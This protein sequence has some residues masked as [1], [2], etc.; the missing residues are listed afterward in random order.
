M[1]KTFKELTEID[2]LVAELYKNDPTLERSKFGYAYKRFADKNF[3]PINKEYRL[4]LQDIR[5]DN[6]IEDA[7]TKEVIVDHSNPRG[8]KYTKE[9]LKFV[10]KAEIDTEKKWESKECSIIPHF[11]TMVPK[12]LSQEEVDMLVGVVFEEGTKSKA[13]DDGTL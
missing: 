13:L 12:D 3:Y 9:S 7:T 4:E 2:L 5:I 10:V 8:F 1:T 6:A 11:T